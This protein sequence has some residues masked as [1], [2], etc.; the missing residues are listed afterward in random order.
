MKIAAA[1]RRQGKTTALV[2]WLTQGHE[3]PTYPGWSRV[4]LVH[5]AKEVLRLTTGPWAKWKKC[6]WTVDECQ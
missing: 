6:V 1:A 5:S 3:I 4:L 2:A